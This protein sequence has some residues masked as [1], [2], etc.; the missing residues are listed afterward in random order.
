MP[1]Q[2]TLPKRLPPDTPAILNAASMQLTVLHNHLWVNSPGTSARTKEMSASSG[3]IKGLD[4][5]TT[6]KTPRFLP[7]LRLNWKPDL[8]LPPPSGPPALAVQR[9][10]RAAK[11]PSYKTRAAISTFKPSLSHTSHSSPKLTRPA[12]E[13]VL[14]LQTKHIYSLKEHACTWWT[15]GLEHPESA[16]PGTGVFLRTVLVQ[17]LCPEEIKLTDNLPTKEL[18]STLIWARDSGR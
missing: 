3:A 14:N 7:I 8:P 4:G 15:E 5:G 16:K 17:S 13:A 11:R 12:Q 1:V 6:S 2:G 18:Y 10:N 9:P